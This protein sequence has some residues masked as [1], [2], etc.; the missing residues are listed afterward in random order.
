[1]ESKEEFYIQIDMFMKED[2]QT[3]NDK[4]EKLKKSSDS[5]RKGLFARNTALEKYLTELRD[6]LDEQEK[7]IYKLKKTIY[8]SV[9]ANISPIEEMCINL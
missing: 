8:S 2:I 9:K 3:L 4:M 1:M 7:E 5:V 6:R